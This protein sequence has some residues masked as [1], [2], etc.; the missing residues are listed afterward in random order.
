[1][2]LFSMLCPHS[3]AFRENS[4]KITHPNTTQSQAHITV[5]FL[6]VRIPKRGYILLVYVVSF[7]H[8]IPFRRP[9]L[10]LRLLSRL[11]TDPTN[12]HESFQHALSSLT[13]F[14]RNFPKVHPSK[15]YSKS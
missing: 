13:R 1:M 3:H 10:A 14:P 2:G 6:F 5:D 7:N 11:S 9:L 4:Q 12:Q 15:Y 8:A